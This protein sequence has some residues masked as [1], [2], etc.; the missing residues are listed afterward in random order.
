M[1][2]LYNEVDKYV[3]DEMDARINVLKDP[4]RAE[5]H[6]WVYKK[7]LWV[8]VTAAKRKAGASQ[9]YTAK[10]LNDTELFEA[11]KVLAPPVNGGFEK[12][13]PHPKNID[14]TKDPTSHRPIPV[15][16]SVSIGNEGKMGT[17]RKVKIEFTVFTRQQLDEY[18][19]FFLRPGRDVQV[20]YGW[21]KSASKNEDKKNKDKS[22]TEGRF[23]GIVY[24]FSMQLRK[25][26]GWDC[27][28]DVVGEGFMVTGISANSGEP[29]TGTGANQDKS[30]VNKTANGI[31]G[32]MTLE[33]SS[34]MSGAIQT[35]NAY[36]KGTAGVTA[37]DS[38]SDKAEKIIAAAESGKKAGQQARYLA[39]AAAARLMPGAAGRLGKDSTY[40]DITAGTGNLSKA[41][42]YVGVYAAFEVNTNVSPS[43]GSDPSDASP[44]TRIDSFIT[45]QGITSIVNE[46]LIARN[47]RNPK[48]ELTEFVCNRDITIGYYH[49]V[50]SANPGVMILPDEVCGS[51]DTAAI[52]KSIFRV[53]GVGKYAK[54]MLTS[55]KSRR[56][57][58]I[59]VLEKQQDAQTRNKMMAGSKAKY[60]GANNFKIND[61][62]ADL[63][64][65]MIN[66][67]TVR[68][69]LEGLNKQGAGVTTI[70]D[71]YEELFK[72]ISDHTGGFYNLTLLLNEETP[73]KIFIVDT[74]YAGV[75]EGTEPKPYIFSPFSKPLLRD[76]SLTSKL[77]DKMATAL[78]VG[79]RGGST[80][81]GMTSDA[82]TVISGEKPDQETLD[83]EY[84]KAAGEYAGALA[85]L[86]FI[87]DDECVTSVKAALQ[88]F[89]TAAGRNYPG[90]ERILL[91]FELSITLDGIEGFK[92]G[93]IIAVDYLP[94]KYR[95][96]AGNLK[97]V[98][99]ITKVEHK[100][101]GFDWETKITTQCR[102]A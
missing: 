101:E 102:M 3:Q 8:R 4:H 81:T 49:P 42:D 10:G 74:N 43:D 7:M 95:D 60:V 90:N 26:G 40:P 72:L 39:A 37:E 23:I 48:L 92:F 99:V 86:G 75:G 55:F 57:S 58:D 59:K 61:Q 19:D 68:E 27:S 66:T 34:I 52:T 13:Y 30:G 38:D 73:N 91:P 84:A 35:T 83:K 25:D 1:S 31:L 11:T 62:T 80:V 15:L 5:H 85:V 21:S 22:A 89:K 28:C 51:Y 9:K 100:L 17:L 46:L 36:K 98:F 97:L 16:N 12:L 32:M 71:F 18:E 44:A 93:N 54:D 63:S 64:K 6:N 96:A 65:I 78:Y 94:A 50:R 29:T 24:N 82:S 69:I 67:L 45:L 88:A 56:D 41:N 33:V 70:K 77:P 2:F 53:K 20:E 76:L 79:A 47:G 87:K 14:G